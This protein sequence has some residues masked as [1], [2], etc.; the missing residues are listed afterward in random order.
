MSITLSDVGDLTSEI[1]YTQCELNNAR[2]ILCHW[3]TEWGSNNVSMETFQATDEN[4][5]HLDALMWVVRYEEIERFVSIALDYVIKT[6][7]MLEK[8]EAQADNIFTGMK[9]LTA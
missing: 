6:S 3:L 4:P 8:L 7:K 1:T 9:E 2:V 5:H